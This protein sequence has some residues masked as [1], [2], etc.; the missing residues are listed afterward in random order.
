[1]P[2]PR[3]PVGAHGR[4]SKKQEPDG[5]WVAWVRVRDPDGV[6]R[7]VRRWTP[8]ARRGKDKTGAAA[9]NALQHALAER[10]V[11]TS[12]QIDGNTK[13]S[14]LWVEFRKQLVE[15]ERTAG[16]LEDYDRHSKT[17]CAALGE[18]RIREATT[19]R[20]DGFVREVAARSGV[21]TG[22][23]MRTILS[24]MFKIAVRFGA[25]ETNPVRDVSELRG[26][27]KKRARSLDA[28]TLA[29]VL[30]DVHNSALPCPVILTPAQIKKGMR[31]TSGKVPTVAQ[32]CAHADLADVVTLFA[33][34]GARIGELLG[35]RW[36]DVNMKARTV[37]V[38]G[39]IIRILGTGL[40][41]EDFTKTAAGERTLPL[42]QFAL[43]MLAARERKG[44]MVFESSAGTLRDPDTVSRQWR[45]VRAALDLEWVTSHT[46][47]KTVA[48]II[49]DEGL[50]A[51][52]A[53]DQ[54]GHAQVS[55]TQDVYFG[56]GRTHSAVAEALD[57]AVSRK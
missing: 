14:A 34:T 17:I 12:A 10:Q 52:H 42:P 9:V 53:A 43:D 20:L 4:I 36:E 13:V 40:V 54:L 47:R 49:D 33:A 19:Q 7:L 27:A 16:T 38:S 31:P 57:S 26:K 39:K 2:R 55:M 22:R 51:R 48:T 41:R 25:I 24:G 11:V 6:R 5:N 50:T 44:P 30:D 3:L 1:M 21:P 35:I 37:S 32:Y 29:K 45:Q 8:E 23:K 15:A 46:F 56:R 28:A 18:L